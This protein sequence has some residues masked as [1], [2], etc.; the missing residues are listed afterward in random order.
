MGVL[1]RLPAGIRA[2]A[3]DRPGYGVS[4]Q[5]PGGFAVNAQAVLAGM[6]ARGTE[7][8]VLV[9]H[10]FGGGVALATAALAPERVEALVLVASVGPE[11]LT[12]ADRVLAAPVAGEVS[13][14]VAFAVT[15]P[16]ARARLALAERR[17]GRALAPDEHVSLQIWGRTR[18]DSGHVWRSFLVEQRALVADLPGLVASLDAVVAPA[19]IVTD[20]LDAVVPVRTSHALRVALPD[21]ELIEVSG[22][23]HHIPRL[24]AQGLVTQIVRFLGAIDER[25][26]G[27][28]SV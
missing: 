14:V 12:P 26:A 1:E 24:Y 23:G 15:S 18:T 28:A 5:P 11:C 13:A 6:D 9:G 17:R 22:T 10:S 21:S 20:P 2:I 19:L 8:A 16:I 3:A 4:S 7:R 25:P 27:Q